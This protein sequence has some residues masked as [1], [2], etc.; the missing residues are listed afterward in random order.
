MPSH[1][2]CLVQCLWETVLFTMLSW[3]IEHC[4]GVWNLKLLFL[5]KLSYTRNK[6]AHFTLHWEKEVV[7][8]GY[9]TPQRATTMANMLEE[10]MSPGCFKLFTWI[11]YLFLQYPWGWNYY[12]FTSI[13]QLRKLRHWEF[14]WLCQRSCHKYMAESGPESRKNGQKTSKGK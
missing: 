6:K 2:T 10:L 11:A 5:Y 8:A 14:G 4:S 9:L 12:I 7:T 13:L 3:I 1:R